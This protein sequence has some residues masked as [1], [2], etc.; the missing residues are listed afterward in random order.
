[1]SSEGLWELTLWANSAGVAVA[2][3][4]GGMGVVEA[5][6]AEAVALLE[7]FE[8]PVGEAWLVQGHTWPLPSR[9]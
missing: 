4:C 7:A 9:V 1:M 2:G 5:C 6:H 3:M 8:S